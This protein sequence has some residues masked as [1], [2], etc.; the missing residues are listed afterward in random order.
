M[1]AKKAAKKKATKKKATKKKAA[2]KKTPKKAVKKSATKKRAA[3]KPVKKAAQKSVK[4][5]AKKASKKTA[6]KTKKTTKRTAKKTGAKKTATK[7]R[8]AKQPEP[9]LGTS[10]AEAKRVL[11]KLWDDVAQGTHTSFNSISDKVE[12]RFRDTKKNVSDIDVQY[13]IDKAGDVARKFG[14]SSQAWV[15]RLGMQVRLLWEM[16]QDVWYGKFKAPWATV[17]SITATLLYVI[18]PLDV[19]PDFIPGIGLLDDLTVVTLCISIIK[20]D[21]RRYAKWRGLKLEKYGL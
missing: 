4:K 7:K 12:K 17:A 2:K 5:S 11:G 10:Y 8:A 1:P 16:L 9:D 14:K 18:M 13:A 3:K 20:I 21:L 15:K 19:I 6:K